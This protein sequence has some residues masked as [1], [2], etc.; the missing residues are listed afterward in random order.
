MRWAEG[1]TF[2]C[3]LHGPYFPGEGNYDLNGDNKADVTLYSGD[4]VPTGEGVASL[5]MKIGTDI[6]LSDGTSGCVDFHKITRPGWKWNEER[7]Y[8]YP[9][10]VEDRTLTQGAL[11]QNPGWVD[12]LSF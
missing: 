4:T 7:D 12:G 9:I 11:T 2:E 3:N 6:T 1:A 8:Y 5:K 10:P